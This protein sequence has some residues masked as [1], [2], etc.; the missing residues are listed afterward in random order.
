MTTTAPPHVRP[1]L[2]IT[3]SQSILLVDPET[4]RGFRLDQNRGVYY[5]VAQMD[6]KLYVAARRNQSP[7]SLAIKESSGEIL[8][9]D[10]NLAQ[11]GTIRAPFSLRDMHQIL[12][13]EGKLWVTCTY[14]N[15]VAVYDGRSWEEWYPRGVSPSEP[16]DLNHFNSLALIDGELCVVANNHG[17]SEILRFELP[18]RSL[19]GSISLG[20]RSHNVWKEG[21]RWMTC[22]SALGRILGSDGL[23]VPT[24][25]FP[26]GVAFGGSLAYVGV[27]ERTER[28]KRYWS[29]AAVIVFDG[30]WNHIREMHVPQEGVIQDLMALSVPMEL[31][32]TLTETVRFPV[33]K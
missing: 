9:F 18:G 7:S 21:A 31:L 5:G 8:V 3:T 15:M 1:M 28:W 27:S 13:F 19:K 17:P 24:G 6:G 20:D 14:D 22:S 25:G 4:G 29:S 30:K 10:E 26:R 32:S 23:Q 16:R 2:V 33:V 12:G 11:N